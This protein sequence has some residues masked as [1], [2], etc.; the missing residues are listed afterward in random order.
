MQSKLNGI[1]KAAILVASL[2]QRAA[3]RM[4]DQMDSRQAQRV[5]QAVMELAEVDPAEQRQIV[6]EF[7][8]L[9][10]KGLSKPSSDVELEESLARR[11]SLG[12]GEGPSGESK[13]VGGDARP[14]RFLQQAG[15]DKLARILLTERPQ[16]IDLVLAH[17]APEQAGAVLARFTRTLQVDVVRRLVDLEETDPEILREVE[18][19]LE[20]RLSEQIPMQRRRVAGL[21]A[22]SAILEASGQ[23]VG[24][25]ILDNLAACDQSLAE[26]FGPERIDFADLI[27]LDDRS[28]GAVLDAADPEE[29]TLA[30][31]GASPALV[32]RVLSL[33]AA[34]DAEPLR[35]QLENPGPTRLSDVEEARERLAELAGRQA[36]ARRFSGRRTELNLRGRQRFKAAA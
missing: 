8:R 24:L 34:S 5:R 18:K 35:Q 26:R 12:S 7:F 27:A 30:L 29:V 15:D 17:L 21:A 9:G 3:D 22:V 13:A 11:L 16:T 20:T 31:V 6:E 36:L 28:L 23:D 33:Y 25:Q 2:D 4:L 19:A 1:R 10:P 32:E 14:F